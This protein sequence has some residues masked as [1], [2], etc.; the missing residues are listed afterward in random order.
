M[1]CKSKSYCPYPFIGVSLQAD[2]ITLPCGQYM[3]V[4]NFPKTQTVDEARNGYMKIMRENMLNGI[5]DKGCQCPAEEKVGIKSMRQH[6]IDRYGILPYGSIEV[7]EIFFDN[8][9]NLKCRMCASPYSH[10][11]YEDEKE[12]YGDTLSPTKYVRNTNYQNLDTAKLTELKIYGGEPLLNNEANNFFKKILLDGNIDNLSIDI[13]TNG[14]VLPMNY[15]LESFLKCKELKINISIDGYKELNEYI[16]SGSNWNVIEKN[17][18]FYND[19]IDKRSNKKTSILIHSAV[20]IYNANLIKV[21]D[22]YVKT[23]FPRF[24]KTKQMIQF[25]VFLNI[26]SAPT[27]Y[28][29][30]IETEVDDEIKNY[31]YCS[32]TDYFAHF[33]NYHTGLDKIRNENLGSLN[34]VLTEYIKNYKDTVLN[35]KDFF[36]KQINILKDTT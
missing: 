19:L 5:H 34:P 26:Q 36:L 28:K 16:R 30:V 31:M 20:G 12:L 33:I 13:S 35:S 22:K 29:K 1:S 9:C 15:V 21:L 7:A 14:T 24:L 6:A 8:V 11:I 10:L 27:E 23:Y 25:P 3:N 32:D 17:L 4:A 2:G 18:K